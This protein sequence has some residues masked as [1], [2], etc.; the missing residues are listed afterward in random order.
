MYVEIQLFIGWKALNH[1]Y[2]DMY[3]HNVFPFGV[4]LKQIL[5]KN[6]CFLYSM[7]DPRSP[8]QHKKGRNI[9]Y[10]WLVKGFSHLKDN[11]WRRYFLFSLHD[12]VRGKLWCYLR[13]PCVL[14]WLVCLW[15]A[16]R[17]QQILSTEVSNP[18]KVKN[19]LL[20]MVLKDLG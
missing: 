3:V 13:L 17:Y 8:K 6:V 9:S 2:N 5:R 19:D 15:I 1:S 16:D 12:L 18:R 14:F 10:N 4:S 7:E 20:F 11:I